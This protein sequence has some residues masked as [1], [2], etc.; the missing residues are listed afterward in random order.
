MRDI[1]RAV[2]PRAV[3]FIFAGTAV[4]RVLKR[5]QVMNDDN[6]SRAQATHEPGV[7]AIFEAGV[8]GVKQTLSAHI[9]WYPVSH[10]RLGNHA[11]REPF[12]RHLGVRQRMKCA[13]RFC[14][15]K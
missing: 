13:A 8:A 7:M 14:L 10:A 9:K 5:D 6:R 4:F 3:P 15:R 11:K 1:K 12:Q 2:H